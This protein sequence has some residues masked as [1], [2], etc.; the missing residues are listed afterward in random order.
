MT[1]S[2][3]YG[4]VSSVI[5][6]DYVQLAWATFWGWLI[7]HHLPPASTWLGAP[8]IISASLLIAWREHR[9]ARERAALANA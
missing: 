7:F 5:V 2:L 3:R 6:V 4:S 1:A 8:V 9:L